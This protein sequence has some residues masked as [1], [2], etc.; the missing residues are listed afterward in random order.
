MMLV[1]VL[2]QKKLAPL[3]SAEADVHTLAK[4]EAKL[5]GHLPCR[6]YSAA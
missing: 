1:G 4:Q 3:R 2:V 5:A 6:S